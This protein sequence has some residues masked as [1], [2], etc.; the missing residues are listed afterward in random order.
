MSNV[1]H[2]E[3]TRYKHTFESDLGKLILASAQHML[4]QPKTNSS[5]YETVGQYFLSNL[6]NN[7][8]LFAFVSEYLAS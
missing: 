5:L 3:T 4:D 2:L 8:D 6:E 7:C 1:Y